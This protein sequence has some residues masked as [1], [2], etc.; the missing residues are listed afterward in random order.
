[1][2]HAYL[3][4]RVSSTTQADS[5]HG[6]SRQDQA[7]LTF[8]KNHPEYEI[9][10]HISDAGVSAYSGANIDAEAGLGSFLRDAE[11]GR[12]KPD[13]ML[14]VEAPDRISRLGINKGTAIFN[15]LLSAK[16]NVGLTRYGIVIRHD[17]ENDI[18]GSLLVSI[19]LYLGHLESKQKSERIVASLANNRA[20][21]AVKGRCPQ[22]LQIVDET[23]QV[24]ESKA[25]VIL[26]IFQW[27]IDGYQIAEIVKTM[28]DEKLLMPVGR[29][30]SEKAI[31]TLI[32]N[33]AVIGLHQFTKKTLM[34]SG[35]HEYLADGEP[36]KRYPRLISDDMFYSCIAMKKNAISGKR[37]AS[38]SINL[39][40]GIVFCPKCGAK[41]GAQNNATTK[42]KDYYRCYDKITRYTCDHKIVDL[43]RVHKA[44]VSY[45]NILVKKSQSG[46]GVDRA[47]MIESAKGKIEIL[48]AE[49]SKL[50]VTL[51]TAS[52]TVIDALLPAITSKTT[53]LDLIRTELS[54]LNLSQGAT[55]FEGEIDDVSPDGRRKLRTYFKR[56]IEKV[57]LDVNQ[58]NIHFRNGNQ[59]S[60]L[61]YDL[62][63]ETG[64]TESN[65]EDVKIIV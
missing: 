51:S 15:R 10:E 25:E 28:N 58:C 65:W 26:K 31:R 40:T 43:V 44:F 64:K 32:E 17:D 13:S 48:Q 56:I 24:I 42:L 33:T 19:G 53:Q 38:T 54:D 27:R 61:N 45:L 22:W 5:G 2:K 18:S 14:I 41:M 20:N 1:M 50:S 3:Y 62:M 23:Y 60:H 63:I 21:L 49:I 6:L 39:L 30:A 29:P 59:I 12:I 46:A 11:A 9:S 7:A 52:S 34:P 8:L 47:M 37:S 16:I 57:E 36:I 4:S 35:K 55:E